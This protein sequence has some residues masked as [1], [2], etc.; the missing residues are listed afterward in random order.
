M[1]ERVWHEYRRVLIDL[2]GL[3]TDRLHLK[4]CLMGR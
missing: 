4:T 3:K 2:S 1:M